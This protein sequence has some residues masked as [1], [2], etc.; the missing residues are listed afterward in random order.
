MNNIEINDDAQADFI[1]ETIQELYNL[2]R[3]KECFLLYKFAGDDTHAAIK[4]FDQIRSGIA[5]A[6]FA[7]FGLCMIPGDGS[8]LTRKEM[9]DE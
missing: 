5:E 4:A 6:R 1:F 7:I 9:T 3:L 8:I 2:L